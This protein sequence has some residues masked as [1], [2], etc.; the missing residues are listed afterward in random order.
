MLQ[1]SPKCDF[2]EWIQDGKVLCRVFNQLVFNSVPIDIVDVPTND[3]RVKKLI[4]A[5]DYLR[6]DK[7]LTKT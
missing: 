1:E 5:T 2:D 7:D 3:K 4:I 6:L